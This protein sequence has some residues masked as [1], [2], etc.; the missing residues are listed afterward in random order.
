[1][2]HGARVRGGEKSCPASATQV[3]GGVHSCAD[4]SRVFEE[5]YCGRGRRECTKTSES[6]FVLEG[7]ALFFKK[8]KLRR[9]AACGSQ[10]FA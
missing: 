5:G 9:M 8:A 10:A 3:E 4:I 6:P 7:V 2:A 1:M